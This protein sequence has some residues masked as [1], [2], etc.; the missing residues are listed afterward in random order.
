MRVG[1]GLLLALGLVFVFQASSVLAE[2]QSQLTVSPVTFELTADPGNTLE[3][4]LKVTNNSSSELQ[5]EA[6]VEN[7][8]GTGSEGQVRLSEEAGEFALSSWVT[9]TPDKLTLAPGEVK[10]IHF[11]IKVPKNAEPGGHYG[12]ILVGTVA[13][14]DF[15]GS[16]AAVVQKIGAIVLVRVS[17]QARELGSI[18]SIEVKNY[19]GKWEEKT[20]ADGQTKLY[21][22]S[23]EKTG[24]ERVKNYF[25]QGPLA[26]DLTFDN[27]GNVHYKPSGF[28]T[29]YNL[30][31][32]KVDQQAIDGRNV[33]PGNERKIT[34]LWPKSKLWGIRYRA[35][36]VALYG[37]AN[38]SITA[39]TSFWAFPWWA[40]SA[41]TVILIFL[42][43]LRQR[44][45]L[46]IRA[47]LKG[48]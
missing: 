16:G 47:L 13:S 23:E 3:N 29:I 46:A 35:Q 22:P 32:R 39:E 4:D 31:G 12:S 41:G 33:F 5:L 8:T 26:F 34:V 36:A 24:Q 28:V 27:A 7:I 17:G 10:K 45:R 1:V 14:S 19:V 2:E 48:K 44:L 30:F 18:S 6:K 11:A 42:I 9:A 37:T 43:L 38:Q 40:A 21:L 20:L 15:T 25:S